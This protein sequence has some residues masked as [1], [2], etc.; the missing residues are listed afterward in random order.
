VATQHSLPSGRYSL[1]GPDFTSTGWIAPAFAQRPGHDLA[2]SFDHLVGEREQRRRHVEAERSTDRPTGLF[3]LR[4]AELSQR[5]FIQCPNLSQ[6]PLGF[7][8]GVPDG[9][10]LLPD[11]NLA[12]I[13]QRGFEALEG[14][15]GQN[16]K[17]I[18]LL[19]SFPD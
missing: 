7:F 6:V 10:Q 15:C 18:S 3:S 9:V 1:L 5:F 19:Y 14:E 12:S 8:D 2:H 13:I 16:G 11:R 17:G 4:S